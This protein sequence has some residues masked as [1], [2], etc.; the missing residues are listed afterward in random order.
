[1]AVRPAAPASAIKLPVLRYGAGLKPQAPSND[2]RILQGKLGL[3][4]DGQ[5]G[6]KTRDAVVS[7]QRTRGLAVDGVVGPATWAALFTE[8]S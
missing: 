3:P 4:P 5:F 8:R 2:V 6:P 1:M 7:F